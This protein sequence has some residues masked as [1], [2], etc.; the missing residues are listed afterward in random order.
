MTNKSKIFFLITGLVVCLLIVFIA[1]TEAREHTNT[2]SE[3]KQGGVTQLVVNTG[4]Q[5]IIQT[6]YKFLTNN[7]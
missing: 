5:W 2:A 3:M 7:L 1:K 4:S 6:T